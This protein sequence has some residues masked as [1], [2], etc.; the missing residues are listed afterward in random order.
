MSNNKDFEKLKLFENNEFLTVNKYF[1]KFL[2]N[3]STN[4]KF[5][6]LG[7]CNDICFKRA[8]ITKLFFKNPTSSIDTLV[9]VL[10]PTSLNQ[11]Y[12]PSNKR[13]HF[14]SY[15]LHDS[16]ALSYSNQDHLYWDFTSTSG[17]MRLDY[18]EVAVYMGNTLVS[19]ANL[20]SNP[21]I[22]ELTFL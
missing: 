21:L 7:T 13:N 8:K 11:T 12:D 1:K 18:F 14:A 19:D 15:P 10:N 3:V 16:I 2:I 4:N 20:T 6:D 5:I 9:I 17:E 22:F